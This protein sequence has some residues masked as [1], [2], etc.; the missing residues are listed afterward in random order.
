M[1]KQV[2]RFLLFK[3][4]ANLMSLIYGNFKKI[5]AKNVFK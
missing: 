3:N 5:C 4:S 2:L 1:E